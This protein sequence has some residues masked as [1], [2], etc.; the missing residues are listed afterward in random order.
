MSSPP[1]PGGRRKPTRRAFARRVLTPVIVGLLVADGIVVAAR[2]GDRD[3]AGAGELAKAL[4]RGDRE[5]YHARYEADTPAGHIEIELWRRPPQ[6]RQRV[7]A[8]VAGISA[9]A[10]TLVNGAQSSSCGRLGGGSWICAP[11]TQGRSADADA[12]GS[13]TRSLA[14]RKLAKRSAT[15]AGRAATCYSQG[16]TAASEACVSRDGIPLR[17]ASD[18]VT[19]NL[20]D[21]TR[22]VDGSVF[23]L[24]TP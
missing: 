24:P 8:Q 23:H 21:L 4:D 2:L 1:N 6:L 14:G 5:T 17:I 13:A 19:F 18:G 12:V 10:E 15:V 9:Q 3:A 7:D 22:S 20:V 16:R 11:P